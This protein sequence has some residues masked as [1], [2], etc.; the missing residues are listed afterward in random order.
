MKKQKWT[1]E[2]LWRLLGILK[3]KLL[4]AVLISGALIIA[5]STMDPRPEQWKTEEITITQ[6]EYISRS[7][8][9]STG[10]HR[11]N[12]LSSQGY[13]H[14][15]KGYLLTDQAGNDYWLEGSADWIREGETYALTYSED[16]FFRNIHGASQ[17]ETVYLD[18]AEYVRYWKSELPFYLVL[19]LA[20]IGVLWL[21]GRDIRR[22]V[23]QLELMEYAEDKL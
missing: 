8:Q 20:L 4:A 11:Y 6:A 15:V 1:K 7:T 17:G 18:T 5:L 13:R 23:H 21:F 10:L 12:G 3:F 16:I 9:I 22:G 2:R 14:S 19:L